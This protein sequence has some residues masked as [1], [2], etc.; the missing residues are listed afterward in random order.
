MGVALAVIAVVVVALVVGLVLRARRR[1]GSVFALDHVHAFVA[2]VDAIRAAALDRFDTPVKMPGDPRATV[3]PAGLAMLYTMRPEGGGYRH[4]L[5]LSHIGGPTTRAV[6][7]P[8]LLLAVK[9]LHVPGMEVG[10][11]VAPSGVHHAEWVLDEEGQAMFVDRDPPA[12]D[13]E[14][15]AT[16][17]AGCR[18]EAATVAWQVIAVEPVGGGAWS[19]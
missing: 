16:V 6:G 2:Q 5:S 13:D 18:D 7:G 10:L 11:G 15:L 14:A 3:S 9:R 19:R 12:L 17:L 1:F 4:H 8:F